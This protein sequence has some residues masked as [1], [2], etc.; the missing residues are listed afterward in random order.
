MRRKKRWANVCLFFFVCYS[1]GNYPINVQKSKIF[2]IYQKKAMSVGV[3]HFLHL[4]FPNWFLV[5]TFLSSIFFI[6]LFSYIC[7]SLLQ[8]FIDCKVGFSFV[9]FSTLIVGWYPFISSDHM[10]QRESTSSHTHTYKK[11]ISEG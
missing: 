9:I 6:C 5:G 1:S 10:M 8:L 11:G 7:F 4:T 3:W 2:I